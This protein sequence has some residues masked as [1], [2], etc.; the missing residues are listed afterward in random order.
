MRIRSDRISEQKYT[1]RMGWIG[2]D[3]DIRNRMNNYPRIIAR[4]NYLCI[5]QSIIAVVA[6]FF[7]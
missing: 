4:I 5:Y 6:A 1:F 2:S 7:V 3:F